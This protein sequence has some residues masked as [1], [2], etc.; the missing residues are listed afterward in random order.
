M[1]YALIVQVL[2]SINK[3]MDDL[4]GHMCHL[5]DIDGCPNRN[6][7]QLLIALSHPQEL[8]QVNTHCIPNLFE[9]LYLIDNT[10]F[11]AQTH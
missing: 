10:L 6:N 2:Q 4:V 3:P 5:S 7:A 9:N 11:S 8:W 1:D